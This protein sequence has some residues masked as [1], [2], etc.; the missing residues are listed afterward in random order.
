MTSLLLENGGN[1]NVWLSMTKH[2][3]KMAG[4][5][6]QGHCFDLHSSKYYNI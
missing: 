4:I 6:D 2:D 3:T 5:L 1:T